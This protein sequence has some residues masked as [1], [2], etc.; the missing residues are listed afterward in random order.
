MIDLVIERGLQ[1]F[2][3]LTH[4][5]SYHKTFENIIPAETTPRAA[6]EADNADAETLSFLEDMDKCVEEESRLGEDMMGEIK[7]IYLQLSQRYVSK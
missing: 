6:S 5:D 7:G 4:L 2:V 1:I 3:I